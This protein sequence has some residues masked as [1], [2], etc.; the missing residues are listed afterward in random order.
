TFGRVLN[1]W[2]IATGKLLRVVKTEHP[3]ESLAL[4]P[5][6]QTLATGGRRLLL[7]PVHLDTKKGMSL[8][9]PRTVDPPPGWGVRVLAFSPDGRLLALGG[10]DHA[11]HVW[12]TVSGKERAR[13]EGHNGSATMMTG[14]VT[15]L[16]FSPDGRRLAS[17]APNSTILIWDVT[18]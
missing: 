1:F 7:Y 6:G 13:F 12:E 17:G 2:E 9:A 15:S 18:G 10:P 8:G 5:D 16:S 14:G 3:T 4:A 11:V